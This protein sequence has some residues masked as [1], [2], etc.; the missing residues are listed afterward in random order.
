MLRRITTLALALP[1]FACATPEPVEPAS[2]ELIVLEH[3]Q[4][5]EVAEILR[6]AFSGPNGPHARVIP[7]ERTNSL[8]IQ[9][10]PANMPQVKEVIALLDREVS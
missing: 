6:A 9:S 2:F 4:A 7:D 8:L 5:T 1:L 3:A 10:D